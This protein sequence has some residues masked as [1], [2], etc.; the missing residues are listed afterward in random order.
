MKPLEGGKKIAGGSTP[1]IPGMLQISPSPGGAKEVI[2]HWNCLSPAQGSIISISLP[3]RAE[4]NP[5]YFLNA[6]PGL[7]ILYHAVTAEPI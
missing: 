5:G 2:I 3:G 1:L 6:L 4:S 7:L